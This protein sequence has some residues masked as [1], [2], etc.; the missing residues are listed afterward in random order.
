MTMFNRS[1]SNLASWFTLSMGSIL[2]VFAGILYLREAQDR[3]RRFDQSLYDTSRIMAAGVENYVYQNRERTDLENVPVLGSD[4]LPLSSN[5]T[6]ARWYTT[7]KQLLQFSGEVP[8]ATLD[9]PEGFQTLLFRDPATDRPFRLRQLTLP[10][11]H[12]DR[13]VGYLQI[14]SSLRAVEVPLQQL[15]AFLAV[16]VPL[17]LGTIALTGWLLGGRAMQPIRRS[18]QQL[19]QFTADASHELRTPIAGILSHAQVGLM[20]PVDPEEQHDRL[21]TIAGVAESMSLLV[22]QL[23][24]LARHEGQLS[25]EMRKPVDLVQLTQPMLENYRAQIQSKQQTLHAELPESVLILAEPDL[26]RQ[27]IANLLTNAHRYTPQGGTIEVQLSSG[28]RRAVLQV[29]DN[30]TGIDASDLPRIFDR[31]YRADRVRS[32]QTGGFGLGLAIAKQVVE[33]HDGEITVESTPGEGSTF[34]ITLPLL[35]NL[36]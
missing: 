29:K 15:R 23:L 33:A 27:A 18:Y 20:E 6:F 36:P 2:V 13:L 11:Y 30:G 10:V 4:A 26:L 5:L 17:A 21:K 31:F 8:S 16:V 25:P 3:L 1:R 28:N 34:S 32:R 35:Q 7:D 24:F 12:S 19:Q 9:T 14:G 22:S